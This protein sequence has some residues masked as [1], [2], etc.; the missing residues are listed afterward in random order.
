MKRDKTIVAF[1][2]DTGV[3]FRLIVKK[4]DIKKIEKIVDKYKKEDEYY[5]DMGLLERLDK[6]KIDYEYI[7]E[8][9]DYWIQF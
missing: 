2:D 3:L 8:D 5:D 6:A 9:Y 7:P 4:R 1:G